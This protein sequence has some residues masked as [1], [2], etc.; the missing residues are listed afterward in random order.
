MNR[1]FYLIALIIL[2]AS[3]GKSDIPY[4]HEEAMEKG[5]ATLL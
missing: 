5:E 4:D 2:F 1:S 3:C